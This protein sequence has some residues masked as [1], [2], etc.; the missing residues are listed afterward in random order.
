[1]RREE[2]FVI[3][4]R[5]GIAQPH[6][7]APEEARELTS[8]GHARMKQIGRGFA[9][10]CPKAELIV[11]SPLIRCTQTA[12]WL[13]RGARTPIPIRTSEALRPGGD[14]PAARRLLESL[15]AESVVLVGHEPNLSDVLRHLTGLQGD[16]ELKKGGCYGVR[17]TGNG[18][19]LEWM[20]P[21]R[22]MREA[23]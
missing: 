16:L 23:R 7:S 9:N 14:P 12:E 15:D 3:L 17:R 21:P 8:E 1:M 10:L 20:L 11:S 6:G 2:Q 13:A 4:F 18:A 5:H 22:V 19:E